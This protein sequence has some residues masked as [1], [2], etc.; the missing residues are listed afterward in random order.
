M[1]TRHTI[2]AADLF[3]GAGGASLGLAR[4][5]EAL[6]YELE[7]TAVNHW[8]VAVA[9]HLKNFPAHVHYCH[10]VDA[11]NPLEAVPGGYLDLL[12]AGPEC[13]HFSRARGGKP[14]KKQ[15]RASAF[16]IIHWLE[17]L[18]VQNVLIENVKEFLDWGPLDEYG[19][20]IPGL[21]GRDYRLFVSALEEL[22]Y[23]VRHRVL[24]SCDFGDPTSR[25]RVFIQATRGAEPSW[26]VPSH[27]S[28]KHQMSFPSRRPWRTARECIDFSIK[29][30]SIYRRKEAGLQPLAEATLRRIFAGV[31]KFSGLPFLTSV[32]NSSSGPNLSRSLDAPTYTVTGQQEQALVEPLLVIL[33]SNQGGASLGEPLRTL[34]TSRGHF[35]LAE[36]TVCPLNE[37]IPFLFANRTHATPKDIDADPVPTLCTGPHMA[38]CEFLTASKNEAPGQSARTHDADAPL[39]TVPATGRPADLCEAF[40]TLGYGGH[41]ARG[42]ENP[43][44]TVAAKFEHFGLVEPFLI[45]YNGGN[46]TNSMDDPIT[47][48]DASPRFALCEFVVEYHG[49]GT[50]LSLA[51]P[52]RAVTGTDRFGLVELVIVG[53]QDGQALA[54]GRI[55]GWLDILFRMLQPKE[56]AAAQGFP[57][58]YEFVGTREQ[59]VAQIG[60][61]WTGNLAMALTGAILRRPGALLRPVPDFSPLHASW[62]RQLTDRVLLESETHHEDMVLIPDE[63]TVVVGGAE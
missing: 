38:L 51:Q 4:T 26:P 9:T 23:N 32:V 11:V 27:V 1:S 30:T 15:S 39:P 40:L 25:E 24:K 62:K 43:L 41:T 20:A 10:T 47:T 57:A 60:N 21:K 16:D 50:A 53:E 14:K 8:D 34:T 45:R 56:L 37:S 36:P 44:Q 29:G 2:Y 42:L 55:I 48:L 7:L 13:T 33:R 59:V 35:Y 61:A 28:P 46:R 17:T 52:S 19:K 18:Y 22:G 54:E 6:G 58:D 3:A 12:M 63:A 5:C 49:T 31:R